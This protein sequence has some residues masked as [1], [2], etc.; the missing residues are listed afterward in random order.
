MGRSWLAL[1]LASLALA[2]GRSEL[3]VDGPAAAPGG[4]AGTTAD[5]S[6]DVSTDAAS[7][8]DSP[9]HDAPLLSDGPIAVDAAPPSCGTCDGC[10]QGS[11]CVPQDKQPPDA[12]GWGGV[13]CRSCPEGFECVK[14]GGCVEAQPNCGP[15]S[16]KGCC[17]NAMYCS[18][19][20]TSY[21]GC[22][23]GGQLCQQCQGATPVCVA[24]P[25]GGGACGGVQTCNAEN[26]PYGCCQGNVC[27]LGYSND[28]CG[29]QGNA[30]TPCAAGQTCIE[31]GSGGGICESPP[32]CTAFNC[33]PGGCCQGNQCMPGTTDDACG[34]GGT[35]CL[36]CAAMGG[37]C[38]AQQCVTGCSAST[39]SGCCDGDVCAVG[40]QSVACG[41]GGIP[42]Q[43]C[44]AGHLS[45]V[46]QA[47]GPWN[48]G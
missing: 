5:S 3:D 26:C 47:C 28:A 36:D 41:A 48:G 22:G 11:V 9:T 14:G 38:A 7:F 19:G 13:A 30:C 34:A 46:A 4:D 16:C 15:A 6:V 42:C 18:D 25:G 17:E 21:G 37:V 33:S 44:T 8:G 23:F 29:T 45:C 12:C 27:A 39:C 24:Q 35:A 1:A 20:L 40:T 32:F 2:C 31:S 43:D 10:C